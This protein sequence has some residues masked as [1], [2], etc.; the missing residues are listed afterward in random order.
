MA[1]FK[2]TFKSL[3]IG[4]NDVVAAFNNGILETND[5]KVIALVRKAMKNPQYEIRE[6]KPPQKKEE[7][8]QTEEQNSPKK[9]K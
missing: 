1:V 2:T 5:S 9:G 4:T 8:Q 7:Q 3:S 6:Q